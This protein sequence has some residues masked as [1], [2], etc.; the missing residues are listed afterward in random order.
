VKFVMFCPKFSWHSYMEFLQKKYFG[1]IFQKFYVNQGYSLLKFLTFRHTFCKKISRTILRLKI[2][3]KFTQV[4]SYVI[5]TILRRQVHKKFR[6]R[7]YREENP[8]CFIFEKQV[9]FTLDLGLTTP[10]SPGLLVWNFYQTFVIVCIEFWLRFEPQ[11]RPSR[12][13]VNFLFI[14]PWVERKD[15]L[16]VKLFDFFFLG[17]YSSISR[18][19]FTFCPKWRGDSDVGF[20][21][22]NYFG[23]NFH[24]FC[25][26]QG[27]SLP[28]FVKFHPTFCNFFLGPYSVK[29]F[30]KI[31]I[32]T[33]ICFLHPSKEARP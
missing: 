10:Y 4:I 14:T 13:S 17:E 1:R 28:I 9:L 7:L 21:Q 30:E 15:R 2:L 29:D 6:K 12:F 18:E 24:K 5:C 31:H 32:S 11:I 27:Y 19:I 26:N 23:R 3:K 25:E 33:F 16:C 8:G 20:L 22:K